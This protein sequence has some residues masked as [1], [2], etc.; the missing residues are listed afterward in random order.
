MNA[1]RRSRKARGDVFR[2]RVSDVVEVPLRGH[3]LRLRLVEGSPSVSDLAVGRKLKLVSPAGLERE[4]TIASH[5]V[6]GGRQTQERL[7]RTREM[8][9]VISGGD[10]GSG[11][12][13]V[14]I[15]WTAAGP[16]GLE[17][18]SD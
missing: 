10:A 6:T 14:D 13:R 16:G 11:A 1:W 4:V 7:D 8:D 9:V 2:F 17:R 18:S 5:A 3:L 15:G 12:A